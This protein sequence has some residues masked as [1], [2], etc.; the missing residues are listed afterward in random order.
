MAEYDRDRRSAYFGN[1]PVDM[2][3]DELSEMAIAC[4]QIRNR[5]LYHKTYRTGPGEL[6]SGSK[7]TFM[8]DVY[9]ELPCA[10]PSSSLPG[11]TVWT[12]SSELM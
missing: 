7:M 12:K 6:N 10:S 4:G 8:A 1:L 9:E 5:R 3:E 11:L 2:T